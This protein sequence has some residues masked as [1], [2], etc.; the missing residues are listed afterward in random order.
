MFSDGIPEARNHSGGL[1]GYDRPSA[2]LA[3]EEVST[4]SAEGIRDALIQDVRRFAGG[5]RH[6]DDMTVV[7]IKATR[8]TGE[9]S[10]A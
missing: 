5:S 8:P 3:R 1:Y 6:N 10:G 4:L 7:V 2:F 9:R